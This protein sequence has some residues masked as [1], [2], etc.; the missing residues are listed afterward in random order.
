MARNWNDI[1]TD[2][3]DDSIG[4][5]IVRLARLAADAH[6]LESLCRDEHDDPTT[7]GN[8]AVARRTA[9]HPM[10]IDLSLTTASGIGGG[11]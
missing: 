11:R 7:D 10:A 6:E 5:A 4:A 3:P 2:G 8:V 1:L 9:T